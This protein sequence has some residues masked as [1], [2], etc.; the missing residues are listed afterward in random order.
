MLSTLGD[1]ECGPVHKSLFDSN[2]PEKIGGG[3]FAT[4]HAHPWHAVIWMHDSIRLET[5]FTKTFQQAFADAGMTNEF[6]IMQEGLRRR[7]NIALCGGTIV[8]VR[9][10]I[11]AAHCAENTIDAD[12]II[13]IIKEESFGIGVGF[14]I[15]GILNFDKISLLNKIENIKRAIGDNV[16]KYIRSEEEL[17]VLVGRQMNEEVINS[18]AY[19]ENHKNRRK[20][21]KIIYHE[22]FRDNSENYRNP[23]PNKTKYMMYDY[24]IITLEESLTFSDKIQPACLPHTQTDMFVNRVAVTSGWGTTENDKFSTVLKEAKLKVLS[25]EDCTVIHEKIEKELKWK[26]KLVETTEYNK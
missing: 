26:K 5:G 25:N 18:L 12:W 9:N 4:E 11:T 19:L 13:E 17:F 20:V 14:D 22:K 15:L 24:A 2:D 6:R 1:C 16:F 23:D 10:I 3:G 7:F 8:S 21:K